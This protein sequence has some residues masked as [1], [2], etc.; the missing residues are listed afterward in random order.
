MLAMERGS[1]VPLVAQMP[2]AVGPRYASPPDTLIAAAPC[3]GRAR[4]AAAGAATTGALETTASG[5]ASG[6][7]SAQP[8]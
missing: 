6:A 7:F 4:A 1:P 3:D 8:T 2:L 5:A